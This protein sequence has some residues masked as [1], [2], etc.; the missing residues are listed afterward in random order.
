MKTFSEFA[1]ACSGVDDSAMP[2]ACA[3]I[4]REIWHTSDSE[5]TTVNEMVL[6]T[7]TIN[8]FKHS[9]YVQVDLNFSSKLNSELPMMWSF[10]EDFCKA[11]NCQ[12]DSSDDI[13]VLILTLVPVAL[14]GEYYG[15]FANPIFHTLQPEAVKGDSVVVRL[16]FEEDDC[17]IFHQED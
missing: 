15:I 16:I 1:I 5:Q 17:Q 2:K 12:D 8:V 3:G 13:P 4:N 11:I 14:S 6:E 7:P 9:G 10:L